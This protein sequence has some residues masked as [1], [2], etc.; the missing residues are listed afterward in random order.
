MMN[1]WVPRDTGFHMTT[2]L[3]SEEYR[4]TREVFRPSLISKAAFLAAFFSS[5]SGMTC[6]RQYEYGQLEQTRGGFI[7]QP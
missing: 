6:V 3:S 1:I 7:S 2:D 4:L 5:I